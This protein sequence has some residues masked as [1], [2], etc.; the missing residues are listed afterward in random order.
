MTAH[1]RAA[2]LLATL[3][4][5]AVPLEGQ[6]SSGSATGEPRVSRDVQIGSKDVWTL[7]GLE[8]M[9]GE[10]AVFT[11]S[12]TTQCSGVDT[13]T[14]PDGSERGFRDLLRVLP[15]AQ[16]GRGAVIGRIGESGVALPFVVGS[17]ADVT[18]PSGGVLALGINREENEICTVAVS[19][20]VDVFPARD[21]GPSPARLVDAIAPVGQDLFGALPRRVGDKQGNLGDMINFVIVGSADA[22]Q[23]AFKTAGWV[24]VDAD[25]PSAL[26][27]G[28][29]GS[30]SK[31]AYL[32]VPMSQL[33]LFGRPQDF[34]W[35]HA[36]PIKVAASRHHLRVWQAPSRLAAG[37]SLWIGAAT[38][39]IGFDRDQRNNGITHKIDPDVDLE[40]EYVAKTL[41]GTGLVTEYT[42]LT[43]KNPVREAKTA[44]GGAFQSD[45]RV[46]V[47]KLADGDAGP[48]PASAKK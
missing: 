25:V 39:D 22:M 24:A 23:R 46:L 35:A 14:G 38:H 33:Y 41:T 10:R 27:S 20:H 34:G 40:R 1:A 3:A 48:G 47:L 15:M 4:V 11:A 2:L 16:G 42:Y 43:P 18:T 32:T 12:G 26:I 36:E 30:L 37:A 8:L 6:S 29:L 19:V 31:E 21:G 17:G 13:P 28:I 45:G 5:S 7:T 44:T 9:P